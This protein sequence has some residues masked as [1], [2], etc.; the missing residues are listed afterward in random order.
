M[1]G[2]TQCELPAYAEARYKLTLPKKFPTSFRMAS[3]F[4]RLA[5][6][7]AGRTTA[8]RAISVLAVTPL[9]SRRHVVRCDD[10][11]RTSI[12]TSFARRHLPLNPSTVNQVA[13]GSLAGRWMASHPYLLRSRLA[14]LTNNPPP[15]LV[16]RGP[17]QDNV[18]SSLGDSHPHWIGYTGRSPKRRSPSVV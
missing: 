16:S 9:I 11:P 17:A 12:H 1:S 18:A 14:S 13:T 15:R 6:G 8:L 3:M 2:T 5:A 4:S 7:G 10:A